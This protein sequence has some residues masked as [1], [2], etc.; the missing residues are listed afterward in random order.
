MKNIL[1]KKELIVDIDQT[2]KTLQKLKIQSNDIF[3]KLC[4][5][6]LRQ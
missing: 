6:W 5:E 4:N 2:I 3:I 1:I